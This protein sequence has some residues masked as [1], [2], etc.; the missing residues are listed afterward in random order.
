[1]AKEYDLIVVGGGAIGLSTAYHAG[2]KG[3]KTL[4]I[5]RFGY[6]NN[7]GSSAGASRQF[8]VQYS[9]QYMSEL[10]LVAKSYWD[11]LQLHT[12]ESLIGGV[13]SVWFGDPSLSSQE[14]GIKAAMQTM[15]KLGIPYT[16]LTAPEIE[17]RF[18]FRNL[19]SDYSGFFQPNGGI[20]NLKATLEAMYDQ[21]LAS[22]NVELHAWE[23][24]DD[25]APQSSGGVIIDT[26][27]ASGSHRYHGSKLALT[28]GAYAND[29]LSHLNLSID[30]TIWEMT[31]A[32]F[33]KTER[34]INYPT[35]FV[36]QEPKDKRLFYG[37]PEVSWSHPGYIRVSP[38]IPDRIL[39][40]PSERS[41]V[42]SPE[43]LKLTSDWAKEHMSDLD[44]E[45]RLTSTCL[46]A[47][48]S[49]SKEFLLDYLPEGIP[50]NKDVVVYTA[51]WAAKFI[52][53]LGEMILQLFEG[54][55][56]CFEFGKYK[57][58]RSNFKIDWGQSG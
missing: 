12:F 1:M 34:S 51:G 26:Q 11:A 54:D 40:D 36:F 4:V 16:A 48:S 20:I 15:D 21:A 45:P 37:F 6:F 39:K 5:E 47:L 30:L 18:G 3:L 25:I 55:R 29:V 46:I 49:H 33:R 32:Y 53:L 22:G 24:V 2:R 13:G 27:D 43:S 23:T 9:Q 31:S 38:D 58:D 57:I 35:W 52:P 50:G 44:P 19:P 17:E 28:P 42:P 10:A 8:R 41:G 7:D 14:G 56:E